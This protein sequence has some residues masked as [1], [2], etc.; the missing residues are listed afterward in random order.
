MDYSWQVLLAVFALGGLGAIVRATVLQLLMYPSS[1]LVPLGVLC[2][3][4]IA[5]LVGGCISAM[6]L[7]PELHLPLVIGLVGGIGTLSAFG[8][9][10]IALFEDR[11]YKKRLTL[12]VVYFGITTLFGVACAQGGLTMG[13]MLK[14]EP[15]K[16]A[17]VVTT[18]AEV[19]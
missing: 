19:N 3:N 17:S 14:S 8:T 4:V 10:I 2:V 7:P 11:S 18:S 9:D 1:F 13:Q 12:L 5:A 15:Q 16:V 6:A